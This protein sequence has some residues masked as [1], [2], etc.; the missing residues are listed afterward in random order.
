MSDLTPDQITWPVTIAVSA[1]FW[2]VGSV[3]VA[4]QNRQKNR[5]PKKETSK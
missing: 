1:F 2:I 3:M 5:T 4:Y